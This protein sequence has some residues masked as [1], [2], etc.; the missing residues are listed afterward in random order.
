MSYILNALRKSEL[1]R[2]AS[3]APSLERSFIENQKKP[4]S[5]GSWLIIT[6]L[7]II[8]TLIILIRLNSQRPQSQ[9]TKVDKLT[10]PVSPNKKSAVPAPDITENKPIL[11]A[12]AETIE[13]NHPIPKSIPSEQPQ[14]SISEIVK[15]RRLKSTEGKENPAPLPEKNQPSPR[16]NAVKPK[17]KPSDSV[18]S[19]TKD[20]MQEETVT[21]VAVIMDT[22]NETVIT[23]THLTETEHEEQPKLKEIEPYIPELNELSPE[24]RRRV[25]KL[26]INVFVFAEDPLDRFV[27]IDMTKYTPNAQISEGM[28]LKQILNDSLVVDFSGKTFRIMRP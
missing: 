13:K 22:E 1:E 18:A 27:I 19:V 6:L 2:R 26:N 15:T 10:D 23:E 4:K 9:S 7:I 5:W 12:K 17:Q 14:P 11:Q 28:E 8:I 24:F 16:I 21:D 25:P 3:E 20:S